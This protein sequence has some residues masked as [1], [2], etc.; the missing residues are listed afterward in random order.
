MGYPAISSDVIADYNVG[1]EVLGSGG[2]GT[3]TPMSIA[4]AEL[5][6]DGSLPL[7]DEL[8]DDAQVCAVG[9]MGGPSVFAE[10]LPSGAEYRVARDLLVRMGMP[11]PTLLLPVETAG[12]NG[13]Y[14]AYIALLEGIPLFDGDL[15]G[16]ALPKLE[17]TSLAAESSIGSA[18][19]VTPSEEAIFVESDSTETIERIMRAALP[20]CGG[21]GLFVTKP[22]SAAELTGRVVT[23]TVSRALG[24]GK[25]LRRLPPWARGPQIATAL[26]GKLLGSG[27]V[28]EVFRYP[29]KGAFA[30]GNLYLGD[31]ES[32]SVIRIEYQNEYL[33]ASV[34]GKATAT[35]PD[36]LIVVDPRVRRLICPEEIRPRMEVAIVAVEGPSWWKSDPRRLERVSPRA[37]G[38]DQD[39]ISWE[40][41]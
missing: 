28:E 19:L 7:L 22:L 8:P 35:C 21:W 38:I 18:V 31:K 13:T 36:L 25:A 29:R 5:L 20:A 12:M 16:R 11:K 10:R 40:V 24:M 26:A 3:P 34:D 1:C 37:F 6:N 32:G 4:L 9:A 39:P 15:M 27:T 33:M 14:A 2:G 41:R 23:G 30:G 17:Q